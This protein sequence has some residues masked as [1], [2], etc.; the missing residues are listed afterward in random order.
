MNSSK[1]AQFQNFK[2]SFNCRSSIL[3]L[4]LLPLCLVE[5]LSYEQ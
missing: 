4:S 2:L 3:Q 5:K 1:G